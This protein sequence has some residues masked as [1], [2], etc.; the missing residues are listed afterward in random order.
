MNSRPAHGERAE[1]RVYHDTE[2]PRDQQAG[3]RQEQKDPAAERL[4]NLSVEPAHNITLEADFFNPRTDGP[5]HTQSAWNRQQHKNQAEAGQPECPA[6][7]KKLPNIRTEQKSRR[8]RDKD[9]HK[10]RE[11]TGDN[12]RKHQR[13]DKT[14]H[15]AR[16]SGHHFNGR[17]DLQLGAR[18]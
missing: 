18:R 3:R 13:G 17:F 14:Q 15:H 9:R 2:Q 8:D 10:H 16:Q 12:R 1:T 6:L 7:R 4:T 5:R 11:H